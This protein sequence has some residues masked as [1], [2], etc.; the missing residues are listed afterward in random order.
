ME[1]TLKALLIDLLLLLYFINVTV[2]MYGYMCMKVWCYCIEF[3]F[4]LSHSPSGIQIDPILNMNLCLN[5]YWAANW[6]VQ[7]GAPNICLYIALKRGAYV[8]MHI[9]ILQET[10]HQFLPFASFALQHHIFS[11]I[12]NCK[13]KVPGW[14]G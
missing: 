3:L 8:L 5:A 11:I 14:L 7:K 4:H 6:T 13:L 10:I 9:L 12:R 2:H 1:M